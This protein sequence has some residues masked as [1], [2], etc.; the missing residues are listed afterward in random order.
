[1]KEKVKVILR[2]GSTI[3]LEKWQERYDL[4]PSSDKIGQFF[5]LS[6][7]R[8]KTDIVMFDELVVNELLIRVLD[9]YREYTKHAVTINSFNRSPEK[10][11]QLR[12]NKYRAATHSPHVVK[13]AADV[14]TPGVLELM[15]KHNWSKERASKEA[16]KINY[17]EVI[18]VKQAAAALQIKIR[19]GHKEYLSIGQT[20]FHV[21]VCPEFYGKNKPFHEHPHPAVWENETTW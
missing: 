10:Q 11:E 9:K 13:M 5:S 3:T 21:D 6:E 19:V 8:F 18:L 4:D 1:M 16:M 12:K 14:D 2:D 7:D 17:D 15:M 20:F